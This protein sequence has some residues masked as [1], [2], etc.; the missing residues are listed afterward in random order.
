MQFDSE[1]KETQVHF[2]HQSSSNSNWFMWPELSGSNPDISWI[3]ED[4]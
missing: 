1:E 4:K 2:L 3:S